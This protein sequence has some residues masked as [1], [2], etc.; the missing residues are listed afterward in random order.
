M[1]LG[2]DR[3]EEMAASMMAIF[4]RFS[5]P[6]MLAGSTM[7]LTATTLPFHSPDRGVRGR[8]A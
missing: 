4:S 8:G 3:A 7:V 5:A 6:L 1:M 2:W